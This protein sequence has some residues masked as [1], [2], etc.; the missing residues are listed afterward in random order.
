[1]VLRGCELVAFG[2]T[3]VASDWRTWRKVFVAGFSGI[4]MISLFLA[5]MP[6]L[7]ASSGD[8]KIE[9]NKL[10]QTDKG[11]R[12]FWL[13]N[14]QSSINFEALDLSFYWFRSDGVIGGDLRFAF[15]PAP[16]K[17]LKVKQYMLRDKTCTDFASLLVSNVNACTTA[18]GPVEDCR[19]HLS[20][21]SRTNVEFLK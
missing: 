12:F 5:P 2:T 17:G 3:R 15:A 19:G 21:S 10:E 18:Q 14:N 9:L 20:Y 4:A 6:V 7:A 13:V 11:C 1:M 8:V 16:S